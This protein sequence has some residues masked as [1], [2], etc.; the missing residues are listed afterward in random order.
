[1]TACADG[2]HAQARPTVGSRTS[3]PVPTRGCADDPSGRKRLNAAIVI[4]HVCESTGGRHMTD[5]EITTLIAELESL[6]RDLGLDFIVNQERVLAAEGES[7]A[8]AELGDSVAVERYFELQTLPRRVRF[9][10]EDIRV[11]PLNPRERLANLFDL[12]EAATAGALAM[13]RFVH[14]EVTALSNQATS[15]STQVPGWAEVWDG[16]V[17]FADPPEAELR[18]TSRESWRLAI[19]EEFGAAAEHATNVVA[20][21]ES[22]REQAGVHRGERLVRAAADGAENVWAP[23][24]GAS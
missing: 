4:G 6:L 1:M 17:V 15:A 18:G 3:A 14:D 23:A 5:D 12:V 7:K 24:K 11:T 20:L 9:T 16:T 8:G 21:I 19:G 10:S 13:E 22:L 2:V